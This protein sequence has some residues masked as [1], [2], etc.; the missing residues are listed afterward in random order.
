M[1]ASKAAYYREISEQKFSRPNVENEWTE[2]S[3][4]Y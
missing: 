1:E 4:E 2:D 3:M